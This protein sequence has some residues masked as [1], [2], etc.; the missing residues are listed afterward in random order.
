MEITLGGEI[1]AWYASDSTL[2][3]T[4]VVDDFGVELPLNF[5]DITFSANDKLNFVI[6]KDGA[7][8]ISKVYEN[9]QNNQIKLVITQQETALLPVGKYDYRL[10]WYQDNAF[11][12]N[13][14][15]FG[16][17]AVIKKAKGASA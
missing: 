14:A 12:D 15:P 9:I 3:I 2:Q 8:I 10:D 5:E 17:F 11:M 4:M 13:L 1:M 16:V 6:V 7:E